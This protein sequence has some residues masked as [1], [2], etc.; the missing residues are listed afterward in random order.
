LRERS[1]SIRTQLNAQRIDKE[2][3]DRIL[4]QLIEETDVA[5][6][7]MNRENEVLFAN[8]AASRILKDRTVRNLEEIRE[9][10]AKLWEYVQSGE[11][12]PRVLHLETDSGQLYSVRRK[13]ISLFEEEYRLISLQNIQEE[14]HRHEADSWQK[15]I[16]VL[17]HEI[18]NAVAPM[19]SLTRSLQER[20]KDSKQVD[21]GRIYGSLQVIRDTGEG[22]IAFTEEY[23]K[24]ALLPPPR[25]ANVELPRLIRHVLTLMDVEAS[26]RQVQI[27][28]QIPAGSMV[29]SADRQQLEMVL[30][31]V[32]RNSLDALEE[33]THQGKIHISLRT[34]EGQVHLHIRDNGSGIAPDII[35]QVFVP[36]FTTR[37]KGSGIGLSLARQVMN[38][39][40]G[41][42]HLDSQPEDGTEVRLSFRI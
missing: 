23:R 7:F 36:F 4:R 2:K 35:D 38:N 28:Q 42:I 40:G 26:D 3:Q 33:C 30:L 10:Q 11:A 16:R 22:L 41:S 31:N 21:A 19:L 15:I 12:G 27:S 34:G 17:T 39:H 25:K 29:I 8:G 24:L 13:E 1:N 20:V 6:L 32:L 5:L 9:I 37:E 14:L 18:M